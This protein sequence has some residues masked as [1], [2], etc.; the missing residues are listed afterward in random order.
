MHFILQKLRLRYQIG[1]VGFIAVLA[2]LAFGTAYFINAASQQRL[3]D[4]ADQAAAANDS[5]HNLQV[6]LLRAEKAESQFLLH[7]RAAYLDAHAKA[8]KS[9]LGHADDLTRSVPSAELRASVA[10][11]R[12]TIVVTE[13]KFKALAAIRMEL[14]LDEG[15]GAIGAMQGA[16][17]SV[18]EE[19]DKLAEPKLTILMLQMRLH[20]KDF[21]E[22]A[23]PKE[24][25]GM[26]AAARDFTAALA[27]SSM[28]PAVHDLVVAKMDAYQASFS[29]LVEKTL[30]ILPTTKALDEGDERTRSKLVA[31]E[32]AID[33]A[34]D[35]AE[36]SIQRARRLATVTLSMAIGLVILLVGATA[37]FVG[38]Q[39]SRPITTITAAMSRLAAGDGTVSIPGGDRRDEIGA[40]AKAVE[41]FKENTV[42]IARLHA[43]EKETVRQ[44]EEDRSQTRMT[45]LR[46]I[47]DAGISSGES[48]VSMGHMKRQINEANSQAQSMASAVEELVAS[49]K[50]IAENS[51]RVSRDSQEAEQ[52]TAAG[53][54]SSRQ[55]V[56]SIEEIVQAVS[57]AAEEVRGLAAESGRIGDIVAQIEAIAAQTNLLALNATIEAARAGDA[58]RG[59]AVVASEVKNLATQTGRATEDIRIR[60][61]GLRGRM[62]GIVA[63]MEKGAGAVEQ[64][65]QAVTSVG[66]QLESIADRFRSASGKMTEIS[67]ILTQQS[68]AANEVSRGTHFIADA[69]AKNDRDIVSVFEGLDKT[70]TVLNGQ[71]GSFADLGSRAIVEIAKND[72]VTFKKNVI[73]AL[74]GMSD[75]TAEKLADHH[76]CRLG[77]WY[78]AVEDDFLRNHAAF[79]ALVEPHK[80]VH[81]SGKEALRQHQA[82]DAAA[83][84]AAADCLNA[85]SHQ[86]LALLDR[87][88]SDLA[89]RHRGS[90]TSA[91]A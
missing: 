85:A 83:A 67:E 18:E 59:F 76:N 79:K 68:A 2:V 30:S 75:L 43:A 66:G 70:S 19:V 16:V 24:V 14:G 50:E 5:L 47:V 44:R 1:L 55:A 35:G 58:G 74:V 9:A 45:L 54:A 27:S 6:A 62:D 87:L 91:A 17:R 40:M 56:A 51:E 21:V 42:E 73:A 82:G 10:D 49:I 29:K 4:A 11:I 22:H 8:V 61:D 65:R 36:A 23:D 89:E 41:V 46:N 52:A 81:D 84:V 63:A 15:S 48:V 32:E 20:E 39:V 38:R 7:H 57:R 3:Q 71:I 31:V 88:A 37:W 26:K 60:I 86:V 13:D 69:S 90:A 28:S 33:R 72:H 64:G 77:K 34:Y 80:R 78:D 12:E 25:D 53:V